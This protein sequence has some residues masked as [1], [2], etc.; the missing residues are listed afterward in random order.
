MKNMATKRNPSLS[1]VSLIFLGLSF[2][3]PLMRWQKRVLLI[4][5]T[6]MYLNALRVIANGFMSVPR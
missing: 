6:T 1:L 2:S 4:S 5:M 3:L